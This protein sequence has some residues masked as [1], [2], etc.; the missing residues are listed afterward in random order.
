M[1]RAP[2]FDL[3]SQNGDQSR[4]LPGLLDKVT[5]TAAHGLDGEANIGP[6]RHYDDAQTAVMSIQLGKQLETFR[7][8]G[9]IPSVVEVNQER[10]EGFAG[11]HIPNFAGRLRSRYPV[12]FRLQ[13][14]LDSIQ[15]MGLIIR[16][17]YSW[18]LRLRT[19]SR[20]LFRGLREGSHHCLKR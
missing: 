19:G 15:N 7:T 20:G 3:R 14:Q 12:T 5:S 8:R 11:N 17:E 16:G 10:I 6:S 2:Q 1:N 13:Q 9:S 18:R 4:I